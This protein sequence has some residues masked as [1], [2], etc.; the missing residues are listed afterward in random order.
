MNHFRITCVCG[1]Y[2]IGG[3]KFQSLS[4]LVAFY[5]NM[6]D[7]LFGERLLFPVS[8]PEPVMDSR[9]VIALFPYTKLP[10]SDELSFLK[11]D[12]LTV[13]NDLSHFAA[14]WLWC[15]NIRT[16]ESGLVFKDLITDL[17]DQDAID[18]NE[19][20]PWY[21]SSIS[22]EEAVESL[23]Q[24]GPGS[25]LV[26]KSERSPGNY[27]LFFHIQK[28]VQRFRIERIGPHYFMAGHSFD[29]L[30]DVISHYQ[31]CEIVEG[32]CLRIPVVKAPVQVTWNQNEDDVYATLR[33]SRDV[34]F[35]ES[36]KGGDGRTK[37][38]LYK[39]SNKGTKWTRYYFLLDPR[40]QSLCFFQNEHRVKP[41]GVI[42]LTS[43]SSYPLHHSLF[44]RS[45]AF[46]LVERTI[47]CLST[48]YYLTADSPESANVSSICWFVGV[49]SIC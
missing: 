35:R 43:T 7:L 36:G 28:T 23:A 13:Q 4:N 10:D 37:G 39:R 40:D 27:S 3:R 6:S 20:Y 47:P 49:G 25:F 2:Y 21:H 9:R 41:K 42:D 29:S 32:H 5:S 46:Q 16:F 38:Y 30:E 17:K 26:R 14:G 44:Q 15:K 45:S 48:F 24:M 1:E 8:P 11:G 31:S 22:K 19:M 18:V 12:I 34:Q 33:E